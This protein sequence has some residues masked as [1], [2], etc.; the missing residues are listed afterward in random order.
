VALVGEERLR[1]GHYAQ[2]RSNWKT[3]GVPWSIVG[4]I[5]VEQLR[6]QQP[7]DLSIVAEA[8]RN[9]QEVLKCFDRLLAIGENTTRHD[10]YLQPAGQENY[11]LAPQERVSDPRYSES[12]R[13]TASVAANYRPDIDRLL[14][15]WRIETL[16]DDVALFN[17][18]VDTIPID[19]KWFEFTPDAVRLKVFKE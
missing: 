1:E 11:A 4:P 18:L 13:A 12:L 2:K 15:N 19:P 17:R 14:F 9:L 5:L 6:N 10:T 7:I 3:R 16:A 8:R